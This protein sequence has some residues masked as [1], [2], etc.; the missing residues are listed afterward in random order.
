MR[1][2]LDI[3]LRDLLRLVN[4]SVIEGICCGLVFRCFFGVLFSFAACIWTAAMDGG[5]MAEMR[6]RGNEVRVGNSF[7]N[8]TPAAAL[9]PLDRGNEVV[10][11]YSTDIA[12]G[13]W[14]PHRLIVLGTMGSRFTEQRKSVSRRSRNKTLTTKSGLNVPLKQS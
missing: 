2:N 8:R 6:N 3:S 1:S 4:L 5:N 9:S 14:P 12:R 10:L 7:L 11:Y 13:P